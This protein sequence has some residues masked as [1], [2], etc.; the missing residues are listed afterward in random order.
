MDSVEIVELNAANAPSLNLLP[1]GY[2]TDQFLDVERTGFGSTLHFT[3]CAPYAKSYD[4]DDLD[5]HDFINNN[6]KAVF[7]AYN[8]SNLVGQ[9]VMWSYWNNYCNVDDIVVTE[10]ARGHG[11]GH[12]LMDTAVRWA[13][14]HS[15]AG[16]R[17]ETQHTNA[18]AC[19]WYA[20]YGFQIGGYDRCLY[21]GL[22][23]TTTEIAV[24]FYLVFYG[25]SWHV[26]KARR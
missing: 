3:S 18:P 1:S 22:D 4:R 24:Y 11:I 23:P 13:R 8:D 10:I 15:L 5:P 19:A 14:E 7:F 21:T 6:E 25:G 2:T 26:L 9:I 16:V 20:R 12:A 17:L